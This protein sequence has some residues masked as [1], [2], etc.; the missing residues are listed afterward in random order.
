MR[1]GGGMV[2]WGAGRFECHNG[3]DSSN[4]TVAA[5]AGTSRFRLTRHDAVYRGKDA[6]SS[7]WFSS[8]WPLDS[9]SNHHH[10]LVGKV[11]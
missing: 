6:D 2:G 5:A 9:H 8:V 4:V 7:C 3:P 11:S 1:G 10:S